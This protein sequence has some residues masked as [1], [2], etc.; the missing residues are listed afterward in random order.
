M[1]TRLEVQVSDEVAHR[2]AREMQAVNEYPWAT[3]VE[4]LVRDRRAL[5]GAL[6]DLVEAADSVVVYPEGAVG[7]EELVAEQRKAEVV[8]GPLW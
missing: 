6:H 8:L 1:S 2:M 3:C 4:I 5:A 7:L